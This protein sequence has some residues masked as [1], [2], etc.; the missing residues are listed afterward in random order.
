MY[1]KRPFGGNWT[2][3][4]LILLQKYLSAYRKIFTRNEHARYFNTIYVDAFAGTGNWESESEQGNQTELLF[5]GD[6]E[7]HTYAQGSVRVALSL[8]EPFDEYL[9]IEKERAFS[10]E[11]ESVISEYP[12]LEPN[13][14][15]LCGDANTHLQDWIET[16]DWSK[17]RAVV[18]LDP[19]GMQV[20]WKTIEMLGET[21]GVDLWYLLPLGQGVNRLLTKAQMPKAGNALR[22]TKMLGTEDWKDEFYITSPQTELFDPGDK[23]IKDATFGAIS[24]FIL[25]RL[26]SKFAGVSNNPLPLRNSKN[27]PIFLL[28][29]AAANEKGSKTALRIANYLL[30]G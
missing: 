23:Q 20:D 16:V 30:E 7:A 25:S 4:K 15:I 6:E 1:S 13:S 5:L 18:F 21:K 27:N 28:I 19:W 29:F 2:E 8:E 9:F 26:K 24:N 14:T 11:L 17:N 22:L 12:D 3:Q 10:Q